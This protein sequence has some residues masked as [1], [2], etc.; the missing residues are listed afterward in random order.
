ML[1]LYVYVG[2]DSTGQVQATFSGASKPISIRVSDSIL[3]QGAEA[4]SQA[5]T[6][7]MLDAH[8]KSVM[9]MTNKMKDYYGSLGLPPGMMK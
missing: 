6:E 1:T 4:V 3:S 7:A 2:A 9:L 5:T 8:N